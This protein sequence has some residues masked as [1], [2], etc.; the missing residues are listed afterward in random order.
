M[1]SDVIKFIAV[2]IFVLLGICIIFIYDLIKDKTLSIKI[3]IDKN[4]SNVIYV[5]VLIIA[6]LILIFLGFSISDI[7]KIFN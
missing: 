6:I 1:N 3:D 7:I 4:N 5:L 2:I